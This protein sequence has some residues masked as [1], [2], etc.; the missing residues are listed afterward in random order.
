MKLKTTRERPLRSPSGLVD[1]GPGRAELFKAK[2]R[3]MGFNELPRLSRQ[4]IVLLVVAAAAALVYAAGIPLVRRPDVMLALYIVLALVT[5][6][7]T[8]KIPYTSVH[9]SVDTAFAFVILIEYGPLPAIVA[10]SLGKVILSAVNI[11]KNELFKI[12]FNV[13]SGILSIYGGYLAY[14]ALFFGP[15]TEMATYVLPVLGMTVA[16]YLINTLTVALVICITERLNLVTFWVRNFLPTGIG[17]LTSGSVATMLFV[18]QENGGVLSFVVTAP[19]VALIYF[20]QKVYAQKEEEAKKHIAEL[21]HLHLSTIKSLSLAIDAKDEYTHGHVHRVRSYA[22]GLARGLGITD[23]RQL[24]GIAFAA[25]VHDIGKIAIPDAILHKRG[26]FSD[27]EFL[28][29]QIHPVVGAEILKSIPLNMP[30]DKI[31]RHHHEK[32]N[33]RGYPD[34]LSRTEIP[35]EAR[36]LAV[37][38]VYDAIRSSR[39]YR[40][41]MERERAVDIMKKERG[42]SLDAEMVDVFLAHLDDLEVAAEAEESKIQDV[43]RASYASM[44]MEDEF[45]DDSDAERSKEGAERALYLFNGLAHLFDSGADTGRVLSG[46]SAAIGKVVPFTAIATY[47]YRPADERLA[48]VHVDGI[49]AD[50]LAGNTIEPGTGLSGWVYETRA[51]RVDNPDADEFPTVPGAVDLYKSCLAFPVTCM[52]ETVAVVTLYSEMADNFSGEDQDLLMKIGPIVGPI[53]KSLIDAERRGRSAV[54]PAFDDDPHAVTY[55]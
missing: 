2:K 23:E 11:K 51:P 49:D 20:S 18:L 24:Q 44:Q 53:L 32:W 16:Y 37:A 54:A 48:C 21:E 26:K 47:V 4:Y 17:Y 52:S 7:I 5:S 14:S 43:V 9:F 42:V 13:S 50:D 1:R 39:P 19:I 12:P 35:Y 10:D 36:L 38:D 45:A 3:A 33:G 55:Q 40:P 8:V 31:V 29:M 46:L 15:R 6:R 41:K 30:V 25:L 22:V 34:G 28:R 27:R